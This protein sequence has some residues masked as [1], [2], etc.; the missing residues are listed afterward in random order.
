MVESSLKDFV[1]LHHL[2]ITR[3]INFQ[4][5]QFKAQ[6][7]EKELFQQLVSYSLTEEQ[8]RHFLC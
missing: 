5:N 6:I 4:I 2:D 3:K 8:V 1:R 7:H